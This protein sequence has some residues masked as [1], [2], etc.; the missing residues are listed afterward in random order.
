MSDVPDM[1][2]TLRL[3]WVGGNWAWHHAVPAPLGVARHRPVLAPYALPESPPEPPE[4]K[5]AGLR[6]PARGPLTREGGW[7]AKSRQASL[8]LNWHGGQPATPYL[9]AP[10]KASIVIPPTAP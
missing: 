10:A 9:L 2:I 1:G 5:P 7:E 8:W 4:P 6:L 3:R